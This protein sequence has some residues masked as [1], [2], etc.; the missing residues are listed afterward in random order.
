MNELTA[1]ISAVFTSRASTS[2]T[3][4]DTQQTQS[5]EPVS[6]TGTTTTSNV[7]TLSSE[8]STFIPRTD[9]PPETQ[10]YIT[11]RKTT[12][13]GE[14]FEV[15]R[16]GQEV[17]VT[18]ESSDETA[19]NPEDV[20][21]RKISERL[22]ALK[23]K[24]KEQYSFIKENSNISIEGDSD[25]DSDSDSEQPSMIKTAGRSMGEFVSEFKTD[26]WHFM[27]HNK[28][29]ECRHKFYASNVVAQQYEHISELNQTRLML[30]K[31]ITDHQINNEKS[32][33][34]IHNYAGRHDSE[35]FKHEFLTT[36]DNGRRTVWVA[37]DFGLIIEGI[38][39]N[40]D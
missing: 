16:F 21:D 30:P 7:C 31:T 10:S 17:Q 28:E 6:Y 2:A 37:D 20:M 34:V 19:I 24:Y 27:A 25:S 22:K 33:E 3:P 36:T 5:S 18:T 29:S 35:E 39:V 38:E 32:I 9:Q 14:K 26:E 23:V 8:I 11:D 40:Y 4:Q 12:Q 13:T 15:A 1:P